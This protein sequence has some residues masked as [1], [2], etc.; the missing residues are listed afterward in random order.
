MS[1][2]GNISLAIEDHVLLM[3]INRPEKY[4]GFT[5][6]MLAELEEAYLKME[7]DDDIRC[8]F[9]FAHGKHFTAGL[10]LP[11]FEFSFKGEN[12][13][14][15]PKQLDTLSRGQLAQRRSKPVVTAVQGITFTIGIELMLACDIVIAADDCRFAQLEPKRG[16]MAVGGATYRFIERGGWGN[17]MKWLLTGDEFDAAEALRIGLVQEVVPA[18]D[19]YTRGLELAKTIAQRAPLAVQ[20]TLQNA[21][22]FALEGE[23]AAVAQLNPIQSRLAES[24]DF[25][26]GVQSFIDRREAA[27][28][29]R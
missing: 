7:A 25:A 16:L 21:Q 20:A 4:N 19:Q 2:D 8:G 10:D 18:G 26:E 15:A 14:A 6:T 29:G 3:G 24:E 28:K 27:F 17:G 12:D 11:K 1:D 23:N 13:F 22:T 5:P 9:L